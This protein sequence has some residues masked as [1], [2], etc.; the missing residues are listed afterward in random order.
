MN[1][2]SLIYFKNLD[3]FTP[4]KTKLKTSHLNKSYISGVEINCKFL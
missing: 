4:F 1:C 3:C 2:F